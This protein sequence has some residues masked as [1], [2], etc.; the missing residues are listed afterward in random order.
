MSNQTETKTLIEVYD[1]AMC[2]STGVCGPDVDDS[3]A[4]FANDVKWLKSKGVEVK[5]YNLGQ[6]PEAFK[7]NPPVLTRLQKGGTEVLPNSF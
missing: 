7:A 4:D 6:E 5:R 1:P 3:L 2:C